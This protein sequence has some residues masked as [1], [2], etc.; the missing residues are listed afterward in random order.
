MSLHLLSI[1][2]YRE[3]HTLPIALQAV[4]YKQ[5]ARSLCRPYEAKKTMSRIYNCVDA[6]VS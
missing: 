4:F 5:Y 3:E 2:G 1:A 6:S